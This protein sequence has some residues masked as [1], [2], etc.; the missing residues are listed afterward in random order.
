LLIPLFVPRVSLLLSP[1][2]VWML[3]LL[4]FYVT[5]VV[6]I[7]QDHT[8]L[9]EELRGERM[10]PKST[11]RGKTKFL[12]SKANTEPMKIIMIVAQSFQLPQPLPP[13]PNC[14]R[15]SYGTHSKQRG[16]GSSR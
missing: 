7:T 15:S 14:K 12:V 11:F 4:F 5:V 16:G 1:V 10:A 9:R 8:W 13:T 2:V 6:A 3:Q